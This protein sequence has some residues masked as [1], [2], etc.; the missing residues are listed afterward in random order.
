[1]AQ[2]GIAFSSYCLDPLSPSGS[3]HKNIYLSPPVAVLSK[4]VI[5]VMFIHCLLLL[6]C[7]CRFFVGCLLS[8]VALRYHKC[9]LSATISITVY[10][11]EMNSVFVY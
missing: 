7:V 9:Y 10:I 8:A 3:V 4:A 5:L 1:M 11:I 2:L 6:Q